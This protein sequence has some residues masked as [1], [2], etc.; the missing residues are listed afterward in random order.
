[1][2]PEIPEAPKGILP[3]DGMAD[4]ARR[5]LKAL[6]GAVLALGAL[7]VFLFGLIYVLTIGVPEAAQKFMENIRRGDPDAAYDSASREFKMSM[8]PEIWRGLVVSSGISGF[9]NVSW[10]GRFAD[11]GGIRGVNAVIKK[12]DGTGLKVKLSFVPEDGDWKLSNIDFPELGRD[13]EVQPILGKPEGQELTEVVHGA[14]SLF[15]EA[16][17][18]RDF[19][20][21]YASLSGLWRSQTNA[22]ELKKLFSGFIEKKTNISSVPLEAPTVAS[23][24]VEN[25]ILT[26][27]GY[28][29]SAD[30]S[31]QK[32]EG[33][34]PI[35][36]LFKFVTEGKEWRL[37]GM[38]IAQE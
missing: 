21:F 14:A 17:R 10:G 3:P 16:V 30:L 5:I 34:H 1:M 11:P 22:D 19:R 9:Q 23:S 2:P 31:D 29:P 37:M 25:G 36:F 6:M 13:L 26:V 32:P 15:A 12:A 7:V 8:T 35:R 38:E 20:D 33:T 18:K 27:S 24:F 4:A 28:Y